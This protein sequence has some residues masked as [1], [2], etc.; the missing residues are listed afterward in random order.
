MMAGDKVSF[1]IQIT[2]LIIVLNTPATYE[3]TAPIFP[4]NMKKLNRFTI[5]LFW[6]TGTIG[7][8]LVISSW[9]TT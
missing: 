8:T 6:N 5:S 9:H 3:S 7:L 4:R 2:K 1:G